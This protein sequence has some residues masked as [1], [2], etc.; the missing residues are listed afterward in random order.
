MAIHDLLSRTETTLATLAVSGLANAGVVLSEL[1]ALADDLTAAGLG[2][3]GERLQ[4]VV[5][6]PDDHAR[7][8]AWAAA[9]SGIGLVRT[10]LLK[11]AVLNP[12]DAQD[13]V[14]LPQ[15]PNVLLPRPPGDLDRL[16]GLLA[17]LQS[18]QPLVRAYAAGRL[19]ELGD[20]AVPGLLA[21]QEQCGRCIRFLVVE[22]LAR[23]GTDSALTALVGL[24]GDGDVARPVEAAL[25]RMGQCST[26]LVAEALAQATG[27][28][29]KR[30]RAAAKLLWRLRA[31]QPLSAALADEDELVK[32]YA[33][34]AL[35][36]AERLA[37][38]A[39]QKAVAG[40][41][42]SVA[43]FEQRQLTL[44]ALIERL[45]ALSRNHLTD[46]AAVLRHTRAEKPLLN[47]YLAQLKAGHNQ[48][49]RE[50][51]AAFVTHLAHPAALPT[52][53]RLIETDSFSL[54]ASTALIADGLAEL[55]DSTAVWPL[56]HIARR[57][58]PMPHLRD[59]VV[60]ALGRI[61]DPA[62]VP[63]LLE[64][65]N[66]T[67]LRASR[68]AIEK[69]LVAI[70]APA[71]EAIGQALERSADAA[72][73]R[74]LMKIKAPQAR[75]VLDT[76]RARTDR[77]TRLLSHL[78]D[79]EAPESL[80]IQVT[81]LGAEALDPLLDLLEKGSAEGRVNAARAL[82]QLAP[83]LTDEQR[84]RVISTFRALLRA[85][86]PGRFAGSSLLHNRLAG[87]LVRTLCDLDAS[88]ALPDIR[89]ALIFGDAGTSVVKSWQQTRQPWLLEVIAQGI[90][91]PNTRIQALYAARQF[92]LD[93]QTR[94]HLWPPVEA[95]VRT[96][97]DAQVLQLAVACLHVWGDPQALPLLQA[98]QKRLD[99]VAGHTW[100][101]QAL[102]RELD[103][104]LDELSRKG[105]LLG[106]LLGRG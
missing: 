82:G 74:A 42:A 86:Q 65:L 14:A 106:R 21:V 63:A 94:V 5:D 30:R 10:R 39:E 17:A 25:L 40:F 43:L 34:A 44:G 58:K 79:G 50:H 71:V 23:I 97:N 7:A 26:L 29:K 56:I 96:G 85:K 35:W 1:T 4:A 33:Q 61:G 22:T 59:P 76:Y 68:E 27:K 93:E 98:L 18:A 57:L 20:E 16:E 80:I 73:E 38:R 67:R 55:A 19:A 72:L 78:A 32:A 12:H 52:W 9:W 84:E 64:M 77:L 91:A 69:A 24:L 48:K 3:L 53:L 88:A 49:A 99:T 54:A 83:T 46:A 51:A 6:A 100:Y 36:P 103:A 41:P 92:P 101:K 37:D 81:G 31:A 95:V 70:G 90:Q 105:S 47:H 60:K 28:D 15:A 2:K 87:Q 13:V 45:D 89:D 11:P 8:A 62:A 104:A 66:E 102:N 75:A